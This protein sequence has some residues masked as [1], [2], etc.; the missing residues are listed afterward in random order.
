MRGQSYT[1]PLFMSAPSSVICFANA[2]FP[3][4]G[5][6]QFKGPPRFYGEGLRSS[7]PLG[8]FT[9]P[10][11]RGSPLSPV[12]ANRK[13]RSRVKSTSSFGGAAE[14]GPTIITV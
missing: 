6:R 8:W 1:P 5:G 4:G 12:T 11:N 13:G 10:V 14:V 7:Y 3:L 2:T 9:T